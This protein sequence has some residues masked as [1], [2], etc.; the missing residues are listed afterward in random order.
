MKENYEKKVIGDE[1]TELAG[2][3]VVSKKLIR[4]SF[5]G[6]N[7]SVEAESL[8]DAT[9]KLQEHKKAQAKE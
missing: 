5:P 3:P 2:K 4:Y 8:T 9:N 1:T 6:E 7:F